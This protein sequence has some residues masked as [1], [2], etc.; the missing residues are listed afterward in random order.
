[1]VSMLHRKLL[2]DLLRSRGHGVAIISIIAVGV[3]CYVGLLQTY[4]N[5]DLAKQNYYTR[6]RMADFWIPMKKAP[7][8]DIAA[9]VDV[10]GVNSWRSRISFRVTVDLKDVP[11]PLSGRVVSIPDERRSIIN[12]I[13]L[14]RGTYFTGSRRNEVILS[15]QF[16]SERSLTPGSRIHLLLNNQRKEMIVVGTANSA[17]FTYLI[18]EGS[19]APDP[20]NF[21]VFYLSR[22]YAE[23]VFDFEGAS[24]EIVGRLDPAV[25]AHPAEVLKTLE[26]RLDPFG[27]VDTIALKDQVSNFIL[28]NEILQGRR[29]SMLLS[30]MFLFVAALVLNVLMTRIVEQQRT[31]IGTFKAMGFSKVQLRRHY[32]MFG[33][34]IGM[35]GGVVGVLFGYGIAE[36]MT[37]MYTEFFSFPTLINVFAPSLVFQGVGISVLAS[38]LGTARGIRAVYRLSPAEAMRPA[39]PVAGRRIFLERWRAIWSRL[40]FETKMVLRGMLRNR[41]RSVAAMVAAALGAAIMLCAFYF[42]DS[43]RYLVDFQYDKVDR[44]DYTV[45]LQDERDRG[46]LREAARLPGVHHA[47]SLL[48]VACTLSRGWRRKKITVQGL[49]PDARLTNPRDIRANRARLPET[50]LLLSR[51]LADILDVSPGQYVTLRPIKGQ[52]R[53]SRVPV[54][55]V[56]DNYFGLAAYAQFSYLNRQIDEAAAI[57]AVQLAVDRGWKTELALYRRLKQLPTVEVITSARQTRA[58]LEGELIEAM[59]VMTAFEVGFAAVIFFGSILN[60][61]LIALSERRR[62]VATLRVLGYS[63]SAVGRIFLRESLLLNTF[64]ALLG[65]PI[66]Y[67]LAMGSAELFDTELFRLPRV[68]DYSSYVYT[69]VL[70]VAFCLVA[71]RFVQRAVNRIDWLDALNVKE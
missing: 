33:L 9:L 46:A 70:A 55:G 23:E 25:R 13:V 60:G 41:I 15:E 21:S 49:L 51:K 14:K 47:E 42:Q 50:G 34:A 62:Q 32:L 53:A 3:A 8:A 66:G 35:A 12:D 20:A 39:A 36:A 61:S 11:K 24:N 69:L 5:L 27:V 16:A 45:I 31:I 52:R 19:L 64:G 67:G 10:P 68:V 2:R 22:S 59:N 4:R 38:L 37:R 40:H 57:S 58:N 7:N 63:Q 26:R 18:S 17:E 29:V 71:H 1:M 30:S 54:T 28:T 43:F 6:C 48:H 65:L 56:V 44:S